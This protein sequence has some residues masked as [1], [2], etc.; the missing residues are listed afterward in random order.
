MERVGVWLCGAQGRE[1]LG[2]RLA[3]VRALE[4]WPDLVGPH[5]AKRTRVVQLAG[6]R[7]IVV[8]H[9][10]A[11]RQ[12]LTFERDMILRRFNEAAGRRVARRILFLESDAQLSSL[13]EREGTHEGMEEA[14]TP[15][16][17]GEEKTAP[18]AGEMHPVGPAYARFDAARYRRELT[19][20]T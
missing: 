3:E 12:E 16:A 14:G 7:L 11:L 2:R 5:L 9:G 1:S 8:A 6:D 15:V 20:E 4:R 10:A 17:P 13:V 19:A 18:E